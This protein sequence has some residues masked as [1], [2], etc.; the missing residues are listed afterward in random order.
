MLSYPFTTMRRALE[1]NIIW[2]TGASSGIGRALA[3]EASRRGAQ[4]ILS[5]RNEEAL[6][7]TALQ[8]KKA[9][10]SAKRGACVDNSFYSLLPF[11]LED[12]HARDEAARRAQSLFG[13]IDI[14]VLNAGVSQRATFAETSV[15]VFK[16]IMQTNF[17]APVALIRAILPEMRMRNAG[18]IV[19]IS[20]LAGLIGAPLRTAYSASKHAFAGF[21]S[22]LSAELYGS[23]VHVSLVYPGFVRTSI[24]ENA[25]SGNGTRHVQLDPLQEKGQDPAKTARIIWNR[26]CAGAIDIKV[27]LDFKAWLG[28]FLARRHPE[29]F[30]RSVSRHG[31][32]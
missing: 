6:R 27:A 3:I 24:S 19:G 20:S 32:L 15:D 25:L 23:G 26:I 21:L 17:D 31:G 2:I 12:A 29:L 30:I 4:L 7:E 18:M 13:R 16:K 9:H 10:E 5:G 22:S 28:I 11:D 14:L 1:G 8:C